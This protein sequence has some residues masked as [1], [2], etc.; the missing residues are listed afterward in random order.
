MAYAAGVVTVRQQFQAQQQQAA[1]QQQQGAEQA[2]REGAEKD[3]DRQ[4]KQQEGEATREADANKTA[5]QAQLEGQ[6]NQI[7]SER[8]NTPQAR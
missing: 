5:V 4:F 1:Q 6:K 3:K 2:N 7:A 8:Q